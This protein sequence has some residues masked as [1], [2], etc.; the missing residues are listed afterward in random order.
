MISS[1]GQFEFLTMDRKPAGPV[2]RVALESRAGIPGY[3]A[4]LTG[5]RGEQQTVETWV[6]QPTFAS[7]QWLAEQYRWLVGS[8][9]PIVYAGESLPYSALLVN[10]DAQ[11]E[12]IVIGYG[13]LSPVA[14]AGVRATWTL[15]TRG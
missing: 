7:A 11:P 8:V 1:L 13:G 6:D 14:R 3:A 15:V 10:V 12:R 9:V 2:Q 4:F 5:A